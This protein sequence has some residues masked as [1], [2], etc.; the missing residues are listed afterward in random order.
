MEMKKSKKT[1]TFDGRTLEQVL[2]TDVAI[3]QII[4]IGAVN[5]SG[6]FIAGCAG[7]IGSVL[8][9]LNRK[10]SQYW[11]GR[12]DRAIKA[13][14]QSFNA[15][16]YPDW[17]RL[18]YSR[19]EKNLKRFQEMDL[20]YTA[21]AKYISDYHREVQAKISTAIGLQTAVEEYIPLRERHVVEVFP[22]DPTVDNGVLNIHIEGCEPGKIWFMSEVG[23]DFED[24]LTDNAKNVA[25]Q[26][27]AR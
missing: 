3:N 27:E 10:T 17:L 22:A 12:L 4:K 24:L 14:K 19:A 5:G 26:L 25:L 7:Y 16:S 11:Q 15:K 9:E 2:E 20:S 1:E 8:D 18:Q 23:V 6:Y 13:M 21:Y